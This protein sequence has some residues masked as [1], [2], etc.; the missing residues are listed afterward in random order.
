MAKQWERIQV[1]PEQIR[2]NQEKESPKQT[3]NNK[4]NIENNHVGENTEISI[5]CYLFQNSI[6]SVYQKISKHNLIYTVKSTSFVMANNTQSK[7]VEKGKLLRSGVS[8]SIAVAI[9]SDSF[10]DLPLDFVNRA[11]MQ[12]RQH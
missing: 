3:N 1:S 4:S 12:I 8:R 7:K 9:S 11:C 2:Q 5:L 10:L 6:S